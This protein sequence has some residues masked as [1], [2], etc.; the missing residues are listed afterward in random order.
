M[1]ADELVVEM[2]VL[3]EPFSLSDLQHAFR[4]ERESREDPGWTFLRDGNPDRLGPNAKFYYTTDPSKQFESSS[5]RTQLKLY[6]SSVPINA[7][8]VACLLNKPEIREKWDAYAPIVSSMDA[9]R[10]QLVVLWELVSPWPFQT[11]LLV[12]DAVYVTCDDAYVSLY[13]GTDRNDFDRS[14]PR[15]PVDYTR[16]RAGLTF[17]IARPNKERPETH[18]DVFAV[19]NNSYGGV[20]DWIPYRFVAREI[21]NAYDRVFG[22]LFAKEGSLD[23][24]ALDFRSFTV[25]L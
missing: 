10:R 4:L 12:H 20:I 24:K 14:L 9:S 16:A 22:D 3:P 2:N 19:T 1:R 5:P 7:L 21:A 13:K 18:C 25:R 23:L 11:R 6:W 17:T 8:R 15:L